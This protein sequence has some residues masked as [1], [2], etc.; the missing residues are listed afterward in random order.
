MADSTPIS[1]PT[2]ALVSPISRSTTF[3]HKTSPAVATQTT[4]ID[5]SVPAIN[6]QP[7]ELDGI[8]TSPQEQELKRRETGGSRVLSPADRDID[9]EFLN[10]DGKGAVQLDREVGY[11]NL[12]WRRA[13]ESRSAPPCW[14]ADR[15]IRGLLSMSRMNLLRMR[16]R[17]RIVRIGGAWR[18][19][20]N[21][22]GQWSRFL[23]CGYGLTVVGFLL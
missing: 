2:E 7:V 3:P 22:W 8:P 13:D 9:A 21:G 23:T 17:L 11:C 14:Q 15:R 12:A 16:L 4:L 18:R 19:V 10:K 20:H 1:P 6:A 5:T